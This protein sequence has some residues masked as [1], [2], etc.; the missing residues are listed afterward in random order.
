MLQ[1]K[2]I[3][4][5]AGYDDTIAEQQEEPT[6]STLGTL[7]LNGW[8]PPTAFQHT[9]TSIFKQGV[10]LRLQI[11]KNHFSS[12]FFFFFFPAVWHCLFTSIQLTALR[13]A[14][15]QRA[16]ARSRRPVPE[17]EPSLSS[18]KLETAT[19]SSK[20]TTHTNS[21]FSMLKRLTYYHINFYNK[22]QIIL[23]IVKIKMT[24]RKP[25]KE[26]LWYP[27]PPILIF[28]KISNYQLNNVVILILIHVRI[29]LC[30]CV[31][32]L[33]IYSVNREGNR[34]WE[35]R[36]RRPRSEAKQTHTTL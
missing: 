6:T 3:E 12:V 34:N 23:L 15:L 30:V 35:K 22:V 1:Q 19:S 36:R 20:D 10:V 28:L 2:T 31:C 7:R 14:Q 27:P 26:K 13:R 8:P 16:K 4:G 11:Q 24:T 9:F 25:G 33:K 32:V 29:S 18:D 17:E 5:G 21:N